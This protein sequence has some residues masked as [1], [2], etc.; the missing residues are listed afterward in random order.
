MENFVSYYTK[1]FSSDLEKWFSIE[2]NHG[3]YKVSF[4]PH[5]D[6]HFNPN[7]PAKCSEVDEYGFSVACFFT[8]LI[9][10]VVALASGTMKTFYLFS[11][12]SGWPLLSCGMGGFM[13]PAQILKEAALEPFSNE[14]KRYIPMLKTAENY[15]IQEIKKFLAG[16]DA[17]LDHAVYANLCELTQGKSEEISKKITEQVDLY[18]AY[19]QGE[20]NFEAHLMPQD[21]RNKNS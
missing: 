6:G 14:R 7:R 16:N 21:F 10:Q 4:I 5:A 1:N 13:S 18:I 11:K 15:F 3:D 20:R 9:P 8:F 2:R 17:N 19:L 12:A